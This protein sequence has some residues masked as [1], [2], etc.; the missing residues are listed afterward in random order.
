M[1]NEEL[2]ALPAMPDESMDKDKEY[3]SNY[4]EATAQGPRT[5]IAFA[6]ILHAIADGK[7]VEWL[8]PD[9]NWIYQHPSHTLNEI[10]GLTET[11]GHY[12]VVSVH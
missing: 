11:P 12:R 10:K 8:D 2:L 9:G 3:L 7:R 5:Y 1:N 4:E 6:E